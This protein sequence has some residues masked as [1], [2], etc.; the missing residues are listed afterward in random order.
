MLSSSDS[1]ESWRF[2]ERRKEA[3]FKLILRVGVLEQSGRSSLCLIKNI[4]SSGVQLKCYA[5]PVV[6]AAASL[7]AADEA[8]LQGQL[9]W[10]EGD[11]AGMSF[12][13]ELGGAALLRVQQKLRPHRR[14]T[15]PRV[16]VR[17]AAC[18]RSGDASIPLQC[19]TSPVWAHGLKRHH[20]SRQATGQSSRLVICHRSTP[21]FG[22]P[23]E[24]KRA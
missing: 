8:P 22:G 10:M 2:A 3:R 17:A 13:Q 4:S 14:R 21:L 18:L 5:R 9:L 23:M 12:D 19:A 1:V 16:S 6:G 7:R 20:R 15:T 24:M 11:T